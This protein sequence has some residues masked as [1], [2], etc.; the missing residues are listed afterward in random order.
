MTLLYAQ[1]FE[2]LAAAGGTVTPPGMDNSV[3]VNTTAGRFGGMGATLTVGRVILADPQTEI[4]IGAAIRFTASV[5]PTTSTF[6]YAIVGDYNATSHLSLFRSAGGAL[7]LRRGNAGTVFATSSVGLLQ[8]NTWYYIELQVTLSDT[9][10]KAIVRVNEQ[11]IL[12]FVGDTKNGGTLSTIDQVVIMGTGSH[13]Y[14]DLYMVNEVGPGPF[15]TFLGDITIQTLWPDNNG[16]YSQGVGSDA[17]SVDNYALINEAVP[18]SANYVDFATGQKDTYAFQ[19]VTPLT[20]STIYAVKQTTWLHKTSSG[21]IT[22]ANIAKLG[23]TEVTGPSVNPPTG[24]MFY[25][26]HYWLT[27]PDGNPWTEATVNAA[28]FGVSAT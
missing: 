25:R 8:L 16:T 20:P 10:G 22:T 1:G 23:A 11:T 27:D 9:V 14:D 15:N 28:E 13:Q 19:S 7:E 4:T 3:V 24:A 5:T 21:P 2:G 18:N 26:E 17:N 6:I 12:N